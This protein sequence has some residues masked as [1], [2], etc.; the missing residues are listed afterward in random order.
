MCCGL[1]N[2]RQ[3]IVSSTQDTSEYRSIAQSTAGVVFLGTPHRGSA[4]AARGL[5][6]TTLAA[7]GAVTE[8]RIL[9]ELEVDSGS[10]ADRLRD[11]S[12]WL[13]AESVPILCCYEVEKTDYFP[14]LS[15]GPLGNI[16]PSKE[17]V[18][19][20]KGLT[21]LSCYLTSYRSYPS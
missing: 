1:L 3:A 15:S 8:D 18:S 13:F 19:S 17:L 12:M 10:Q 9:K 7:P 6:I 5:L 4:A 14:S 16:I 21:A 20:P 11:F 2:N